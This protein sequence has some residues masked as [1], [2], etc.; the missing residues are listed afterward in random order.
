MRL[1]MRGNPRSVY[2]PLPLTKLEITDTGIQY[3]YA[4]NVDERG[5]RRGGVAVNC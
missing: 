3:T 4:G 2:S 1:G 5:E